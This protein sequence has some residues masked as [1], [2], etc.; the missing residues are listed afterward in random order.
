MAKKASSKTSSLKSW[1]STKKI[2]DPDHPGMKGYEIRDCYLSPTLAK[3]SNRG[4]VVL[5]MWLAYEWFST[6]DYKRDPDFYYALFPLLGLFGFVIWW[7][8]RWLF[9]TMFVI[10]IFSGRMEVAGIKEYWVFEPLQRVMVGTQTTRAGEIEQLE[11][12]RFPRLFG[13]HLNSLD[14]FIYCLDEPFRLG[15]FYPKEK[16]EMLV[17]R[18]ERVKNMFGLEHNYRDDD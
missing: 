13:Y 12:Q 16:A 14:V 15:C 7:F 18:L 1:P 10:R 3:I 6:V 9:Q 5:V 11:R 2:P 17:G 8:L 4:A